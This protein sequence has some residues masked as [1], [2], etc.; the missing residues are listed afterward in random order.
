MPSSGDDEVRSETPGLGGHE[1]GRGPVVPRRGWRGRPPGER[2]PAVPATRSD[3]GWW[4][5]C[6]GIG[7]VVGQIVALV[8]ITVAAQITGNGAHLTAISKLAAP[9]AWY[10]GSGLVGL[11]T[12]FFFGPAIASRVRG[13]RH[14]VADLGLSFRRSDAWGVLIGIGGQLLVTLI[15]LPFVSHLHNFQAPTTKLTGGAHGTGFAVI[16]ILTVVGAPFFEELFFRGLLLRGLLGVFGAAGRRLAGAATPV[17]AIAVAVVADGLLFGLA[18]GEL[19]Q[20]AGLAVF[21]C[22]LAVVAYKTG[23]LG[24]NMVAHASFNLVA[25]IAIASNRAG[26]I[27]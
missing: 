21:G 26:L 18:H 19:E 9:P 6:A 4:L 11:W 12:G 22:I 27:H 25:V 8:V 2:R 1:S 16:A 13:T 5:V 24:M 14:L 23:R 3:G 7:F 17:L 20:F 15:Y 10:I